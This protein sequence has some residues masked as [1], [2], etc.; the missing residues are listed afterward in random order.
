MKKRPKSS[1]SYYEIKEIS[2]EMYQGSRHKF[3]EDMLKIILKYGTIP[4]PKPHHLH[5]ITFSIPTQ[6]K[7]SFVIGL[8]Y[9]KPDSSYTEDHILVKKGRNMII[10]SK[11]ELEIFLPE[12]VG[13]HKAQPNFIERGVGNRGS[14]LFFSPE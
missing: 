6:V 10:F 3:G 14:G 4:R 8:R 1:N 5:A 7:N 2:D 11:R 12:Y 9:L 13:A